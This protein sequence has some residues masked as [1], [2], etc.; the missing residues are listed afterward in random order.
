MLALGVVAAAVAAALLWLLL[1]PVIRRH[2]NARL[3]QKALSRSQRRLLKKSVALYKRLPKALKRRL[4]GQIQVFLADKS[5]YGCAGFEINEQVR[6][7]IAGQACLLCLQPQADCY[8]GLHSVLVYPS[9][10]YV[11]HGQP[12]E[13]G[14]VSDTPDLLAGE[15]WDS[16]R[17]IL[18]WDDVQAA[19]ENSP[20]NVIVHEFAHQL[21]FENPQAIGAPVLTDYS[22]WSQVFSAEFK[23][24]QGSH[25]PVLDAYGATNP[26]E[27]FAVATEA[28]IQSGEDL[29]EHHADLY[30]LL[31]DYYGL[32]TAH[33]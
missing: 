7:T 22:E 28:Y 17:I 19:V 3:A 29:A 1:P 11:Q 14:L 18:S 20:H 8:P 12:D 16:G 2:R 15:A 24:L 6:I 13:L 5:F 10:F 32:D 25:S 21:D 33:L 27:F 30:R 4:E 26:A 23:R 31:R 9:A